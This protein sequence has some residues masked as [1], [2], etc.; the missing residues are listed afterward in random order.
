M[1]RPR[2]AA[3]EAGFLFILGLTSLIWT[4]HTDDARSISKKLR[5]LHTRTRIVKYKQ[6]GKKKKKKRGLGFASTKNRTPATVSGNEDRTSSSRRETSVFFCHTIQIHYHMLLFAAFI[7]ALN[8]RTRDCRIETAK[9]SSFVRSAPP[10]SSVM[11]MRNM[12]YIFGWFC[13]KQASRSYV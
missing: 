11:C 3:A 4:Q 9:R 12:W 10:V 6:E 7:I 1:I 5:A 2:G 13:Q 8:R